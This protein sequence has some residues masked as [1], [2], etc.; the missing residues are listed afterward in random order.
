M[1]REIKFRAWDK[2]RN[3]M[4]P[5]QKAAAVLSRVSIFDLV[6]CPL[7]EIVA[8][9]AKFAGLTILNAYDVGNFQTGV[10]VASGEKEYRVRLFETFMFC[11]CPGFFF[12]HKCRHAVYAFSKVDPQSYHRIYDQQSFRIKQDTLNSM[13]LAAPAKK[14]EYR[15]SPIPL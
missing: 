12:N 2:A 15:G 9:A 4:T 5:E 3:K 1:T 14:L 8:Q 7:E 6:E 11:E 10:L 13:I